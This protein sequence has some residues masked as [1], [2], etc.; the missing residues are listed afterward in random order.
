MRVKIEIVDLPVHPPRER[1]TWLMQKFIKLNYSSKDLLR[2]N[3]VC[4]HQEVLF[5]S[6][7]MDASSRALDRKYLQQ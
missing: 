2:L 5:L 3:R 6:D 4:L 1:D 7:V